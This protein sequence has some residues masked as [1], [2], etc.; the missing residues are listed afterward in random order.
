MKKIILLSFVFVSGL[1]AAPDYRALKGN[2]EFLDN[3]SEEADV[4]IG[5]ASGYNNTG[6]K[7]GELRHKLDEKSTH[8]HY[9]GHSGWSLVAAGSGGMV[10]GIAATVG[11][12]YIACHYGYERILKPDVS[13]FLTMVEKFGSVLATIT[14]K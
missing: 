9:H 1:F 7:V 8:H 14:K 3:Y 2:S 13:K 6:I 12:T 10:L 11:I 4:F 5:N